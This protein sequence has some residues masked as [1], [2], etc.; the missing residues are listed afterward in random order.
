MKLPAEHIAAIQTLGYTEDEARFL[1]I[2]ATHS[3]YFLPR[4]FIA[5]T[6]A[7]WGKRSQHFTEKLQ[8]HGHAAWREYYDMGGVYHV[9]S[10][11]LYRLMGR[12]NLRNRRRHSAEFIR[13]RLLLLDFLLANPEHDYFE[14]EDDKVRFFCE[15]RGIPRKV[16]PVKAYE[17]AT[18]S[19]PTLRYFVDKFPMFLD[20]PT[21][22]SCPVVTFSYV[23]PGQA[24]LAGLAHH[25]QKYGSLFGM[26][27]RFRFLYIAASPVHFVRA[28]ECF[29]FII[30]NPLQQMVP[31]ELERYFRL[32]ETWELKQY[33]SLTNEDIEWLEE[34]N[35]RFQGDR[36]EHM[37]HLW[38]SAGHGKQD[39]RTLLSEPNEARKAEF[40]T[41][42]VARGRVPDAPEEGRSE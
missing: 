29:S 32:R 24:T 3:G 13:T 15:E 10:K 11:A 26:L 41:Y 18:D 1:H 42:L 28:E 31:E 39:W 20:C 9:F 37:Y 21:D 35:Q 22:S 8:K 2:V 16:L 12:E 17:G 33:G 6:G 34:A 4:Q 25:L 5:F 14:T 36:V 38:S 7:H 30:R 23:D 27:D 19:E 40:G